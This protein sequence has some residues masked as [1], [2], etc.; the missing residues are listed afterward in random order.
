[1][2]DRFVGLNSNYQRIAETEIQNSVC[3]A[4]V[5][6][7]V[8]NAKEGEKVYFQRVEIIDANT[9]PYCKRMEGKIAVWSDVPLANERVKDQ[10]A[11]FA[12][13]EGK[14]WT[15]GKHIAAVGCFHPYCRGFWTRWVPECK[16]ADAYVAE[17][18]KRGAKWKEAVETA[19]KE[20]KE[21]GIESPD[22]RTAGFRERIEELFA[23]D[24]GAENG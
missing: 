24:K 17:I 11:D 20:F 21:K 16:A 18:F 7:E 8:H 12:I 6:E 19:K 4:I 13:W 23:G 5:R 9:C 3:G 2:F 15:G 10:Y 14:E 22:D 1:M